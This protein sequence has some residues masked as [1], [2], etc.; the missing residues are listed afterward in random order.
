M[1][2]INILFVFSAFSF[3]AFCQ[4]GKSKF[5]EVYI[6]TIP[7]P[8]APANLEVS[9]ISFD[10]HNWNNNK[11]LDAN[12]Q[13]EIKFTVTN[14]GKGDA[15]SLV[16]QIKEAN[17]VKG[18]EFIPEQSFGTL[19]AGKEMTLSV[20]IS[21]M[22]QLESGKAEFEILI[23]EGNHFDA[24]LFKV[25]FTTQKFKN[26]LVTIADHKFSTNEEGKV[27]LG[28]PLSLNVVVQNQGQG[29]ASEVNITFV[30]PTNVFPANEI[31]YTISTLK[32]NET[33]NITYEFFANK[34][35]EGR[36]I[37]ISVKI[38]E[39]YGKY[40]GI[41]TL[42]VSL[43]QTL[44]KTKQIDVNAQYEKQVKIDNVSLTSDV[45]KDIPVNNVTYENKYALIIG[46]ED[47]VSF[48]QNLT[49][50]MNV[51][52]AINDALM[53]K[54][55][56][57]KTFGIPENNITLKL[58][59]TAGQINQAIDKLN[60]LIKATN[61]EADVIV[62]YAGHGLPDE[63]TKEPYL[64]PVDVNGTNLSS[65]IKLSNLYSKL[66]EFPSKK[67]TVFMDACFSGGGRDAGL[68]ASR[69]V[70]IKPKADYLKGNIIVFSSSS[71]EQSSLPWK[72]QQHGM[73]TYFLLK[74][75]QNTNGD[76]YFSELGRR[77][78][79]KVGL[80]SLRTNSKEQHPQVF[81]SDAVK[82]S[83]MNWK[84]K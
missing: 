14:T 18:M 74:E 6:S 71:G 77:L 66:T 44:V 52:F 78:K 73:F 34:K 15:Y 82:E 37:P 48:Q 50:E 28:Y 7:K 45:D 25:F 80:E 83:W 75:F 8:T 38:S 13:A 84:L 54:E 11:M 23:T 41:K 72:K 68:L 29:E 43:E 27:K 20:P 49:N 53:F 57:L 4:V 3:P 26:P 63:K 70:N 30:N 76:I 17:G 42:S 64:I 46:N 21:G 31:S 67:V 10:D 24:D 47:Y 39:S 32:P 51:E 81:L 36:E 16:A 55:Y 35:Y 9:N 12:E 40:G 33:K 60:K 79:E 69:G 58:N 5:K 65:A 1:R 62:Y 56:C 2:K 19:T 22:M 59:A 61:G